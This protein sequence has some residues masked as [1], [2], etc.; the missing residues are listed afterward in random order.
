MA[1]EFVFVFLKLLHLDVDIYKSQF[2]A[3]HDNGEDENEDDDNGDEVVQ[4]AK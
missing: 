2:G 3:N 1:H 4:S